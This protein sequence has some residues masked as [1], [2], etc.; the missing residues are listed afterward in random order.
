MTNLSL[1]KPPSVG[2]SG[3][4]KFD[5]GCNPS[6][7]VRVHVEVSPF[8]WE[9]F[10]PYDSTIARVFM[11]FQNPTTSSSH[12]NQF[13]WGADGTTQGSRNTFTFKVP[14]E[15]SIYKVVVWS[16]GM[17]ANAVQFYTRFG[18]ISPLYGMEVDNSKSTTFQAPEGTDSQLVGV[19]GRFGGIIDS[20]DFAFASLEEEIGGV[21]PKTICTREEEDG[22]ATVSHLSYEVVDER[23]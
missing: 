7:V 17:V 22:E 10:G 9:R 3:G 13:Y 19:Y 23:A 2:G 5:S 16:D 11:D 20:L 4:H 1:Y 12:K 8:H 15:D 14:Q 18:Y 21:V 6:G